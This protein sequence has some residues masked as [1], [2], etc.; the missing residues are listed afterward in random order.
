MYTGINEPNTLTKHIP[1][2]YKCWC[3]CKNAMYVKMIMF[4]ILVHVAVKMENI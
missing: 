4:R 1:F 2:E 3:E